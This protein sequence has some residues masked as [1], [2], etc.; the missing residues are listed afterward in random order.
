MPELFYD[1]LA[2]VPEPFKEFAK[3]A[4]DEKGNKLG[5]LSINVVPNSKLQEFRENNERL[6]KERDQ[7]KQVVDKYGHVIGEDFDAFQNHLE[8]LKKTKKRVDDGELVANSSLE[9]ALAKRT[10]EMKADLEGKNQ[11]LIKDRDDWKRRAEIGDQKFKQTVIER[12]VTDAILD[13]EVG[14]LANARPDILNRAMSVFKVDDK[15]QIRAFDNDGNVIYG[16]DGATP[17]TPKDWLVKLKESAPYF[18]ETS[19]GAGAGGSGIPAINGR[20][21]A[22]Q[23]A[24][25]SQEEYNEARKKGLIK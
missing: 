23:I 20:L 22:D 15:G 18:F 5:K 2:D 12:S 14:A 8:E 7:L 4:V 16:P 9:E 13:K 1:S 3:D 25:M 24:K 10:Q 19:R 17:M 11:A 21:S 6:S